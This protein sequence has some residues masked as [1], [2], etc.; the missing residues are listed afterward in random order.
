MSAKEWS[1][2]PFSLVRSADDVTVGP[3]RDEGV[4]NGGVGRVELE[5]WVGK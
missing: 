4:D 2:A 5:G 3:V 1:V